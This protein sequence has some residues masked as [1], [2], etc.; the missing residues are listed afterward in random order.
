M[1]N[2]IKIEHWRNFLESPVH[3]Y[4]VKEIEDQIILAREAG[5]LCTTSEGPDGIW[6]VLGR[7]KTFRNFLEI[8]NNEHFEPI[9]EDEN[10]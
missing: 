10:V 9:E 7:V 6:A 3:E 2:Q 1:K 5:D 4:L 8:L